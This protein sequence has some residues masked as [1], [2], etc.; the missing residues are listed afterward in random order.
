M[1]GTG[2]PPAVRAGRAA[3]RG[4][5]AA[6]GHDPGAGQRPWIPPGV[7]R[8][9]IFPARADRWRGWRTWTPISASNCIC[10]WR[11]CWR[12][13][14]G[15]AAAPRRG[16][17]TASP[18]RN[19]TPDATTFAS[20]PAAKAAELRALGPELRRIAGLAAVSERTLRRWAEA[21]WRFGIAGCIDGRT[22]RGPTC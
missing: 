21:Y 19:T 18:A 14:P 6:A 16:R 13:K 3:R 12:P 11:R 10:G 5:P 4:R 9:V 7:G 2:M 22:L 20:R 15:S 8:G 1:D 17:L